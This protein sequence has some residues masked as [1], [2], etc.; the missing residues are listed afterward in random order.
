MRVNL[1]AG[2]ILEPGYVNH[3]IVALPGIDV[4]HDLD[5]APWPWADGSLERLRAFDVFEHVSDPLIFMQESWR[6][7][8]RGACLEMHTCYW[9]SQNAYTDPTHRRFPTMETFDY[10][11]AGTYLNQR[12][13]AAYTGG[14]A[15]FE[16]LKVGLDGTELAVLLK[17]PLA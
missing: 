11:C 1:G 14:F 7:L 10:W 8:R 3:D 5:I 2:S 16:K 13:G 4:I 17:K 15:V 6:V 9:R 12:Y